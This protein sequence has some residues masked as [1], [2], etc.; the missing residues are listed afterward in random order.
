MQV[1]KVF[2]AGNL[3]RD[4]EAS[5]VTS[6]QAVTNLHIATNRKYKG[7]NGQVKEEVTYVGVEVWGKAAED[8]AKFLK[9]GSTV[10]VE[11]RLKLKEWVPK[12]ES[13]KRSMLEVVCERIQFIDRLPK[14][15]AVQV[16]GAVADS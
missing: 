6:G 10:H 15:G 16:D 5:V 12:G 3:A 8:C 13:Q 1:N 9:K 7:G 11:G 14:N 4:P 2:I